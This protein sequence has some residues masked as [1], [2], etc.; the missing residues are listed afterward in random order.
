MTDKGN[1]FMISIRGKAAFEAARRFTAD[2]CYKVIRIHGRPVA[3]AEIVCYDENGG[4]DPEEYWVD[5]RYI[6]RGRDVRDTLNALEKMGFSGLAYVVR[7]EKKECTTVYNGHEVHYTADKENF[8][9][10]CNLYSRKAAAEAERQAEAA[11]Q[12]EAER[13]RQAAAEAEKIVLMRYSAYKSHYSDCKTVIGSYD[14]DHK[15]ISVIVPAGRM[16]PSGTRGE[17]FHEYTFAYETEN[18]FKAKVYFKA[19]CAANAERRFLKM[20]RENGFTP[21][22]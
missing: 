7:L 11:R 2:H 3:Q 14:A 13:Q 16:K 18:G 4:N 22:T 15:T 20:C 10:A 8:L 1:Y 6:E 12:A 9:F 19:V 21:L 17:R 5:V